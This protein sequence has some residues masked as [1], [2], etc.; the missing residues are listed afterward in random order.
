MDCKWTDWAQWGK[1][2]KP[3]GGGDR[4]R[5]RRQEQKA[6]NGG[7]V[8]KGPAVE[9]EQCNRDACQEKKQQKK[10]GTD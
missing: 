1:C 9:T 8:C 7:Q 5:R 10:K 3:C 4:T 6:A 2:S